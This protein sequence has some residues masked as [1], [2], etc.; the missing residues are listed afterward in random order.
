V[1]HRFP[2]LAAEVMDDC[3][4]VTTY[5][6]AISILNQH[7]TRQLLLADPSAQGPVVFLQG[8]SK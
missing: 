6:Q 7:Q 2:W 5:E 4:A 8:I 1:L 3:V